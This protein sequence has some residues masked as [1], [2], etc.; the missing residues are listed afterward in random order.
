MS[1]LRSRL[2]RARP[3]LLYGI[4]LGVT[5]V[6]MRD[7]CLHPSYDFPPPR[8]FAGERWYNPYEETVS[9]RLRACFH[10][11]STDSLGGFSQATAPFESL[12]AAYRRLGYD[13][14]GI[15]EY[16][17][18]RPEVAE[19]DGRVYVRVYEHGYGAGKQHQTVIGAG[20]IE[21][22]DYICGQSLEQKQHVLD[23]LGEPG[24]F[25][26]ANHPNKWQ[27]YAD[28]DF[29]RLTGVHGIEIETRYSK[30]YVH[31]DRA[32]SAGRPVWGICSDDAHRPERSWHVGSGWVQLHAKERS[33]A[34]VLEA[35]RSGRFESV[36]AKSGGAPNALRSLEVVRDGEGERLELALVRPAEWLHAIGQG[37]EI[38]RIANHA[39]ALSI[40]LGPEITYVRFAA[41][42][43]N[44]FLSLNPVFRTDAADPVAAAPRATI[45]PART[46]L[47][48][49]L[50]AA[51]GLAILALG[52]ALALE[53]RRARSAA[54]TQGSA[55][56][57]A[58][59]GVPAPLGEHLDGA[60]AA[61]A[62]EVRRERDP[63]PAR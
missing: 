2:R 29:D 36:W 51:W 47:R 20:R 5:A 35:L 53:G 42:T 39:A 52:V 8:P 24:V 61:Q 17:A 1:L 7:F 31:W 59:N 11:H 37:G 58:D 46:A 13:V 43:D 32:L 26:V 4:L 49:A 21:W 23:L 30:G 14:I 62:F 9:G 3:W 16:Q 34:G 41:K 6:A 40:P 38:F 12:H 48:R 27:G 10:A 33:E 18:I 15:S 22:R 54:A 25:I 28:E 63:D 56:A 45:A 55:R 60:D 44:T 57:E 50:G 19:D